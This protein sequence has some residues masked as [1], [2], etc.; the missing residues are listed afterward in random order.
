M[1]SR[2]GQKNKRKFCGIVNI[3]F[4]WPLGREPVQFKA[5]VTK[6]SGPDRQCRLYVG[7]VKILTLVPT[8]ARA[9]N[10]SGRRS[11]GLE[12]TATYSD[13]YLD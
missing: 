13:I 5:H 7:G 9:K 11:G 1:K 3:M 2:S 6:M 12:Q 4:L 8:E 10:T